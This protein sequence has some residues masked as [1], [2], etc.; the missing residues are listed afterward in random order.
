M[1]LDRIAKLVRL[2]AADADVVS[3][4]Q[5]QPAK[6][7]VP[8]NLDPDHLRVLQ[9]AKATAAPQKT[10]AFGQAQPRQAAIET[11]GSAAIQP[12]P[13]AA[14]APMP[15][16]MAN[17]AAP[18]TDDV[19]LPPEGA[20]QPPNPVII[21]LAPLPSPAPTRQPA[22][23]PPAS[24]GPTRQPQPAPAKLNPAPSQ[25]GPATSPT[26]PAPAPLRAP[27]PLGPLPWQ[28]QPARQPFGL[29]PIYPLP[30]L[31]T[32]TQLQPVSNTPDGSP[33]PTIGSPI[34]TIASQIPTIAYPIPTIAGALGSQEQSA[35]QTT[36]TQMAPAFW[37]P[38]NAAPCDCRL[39]VTALAAMVATTSQTAITAITGIAQQC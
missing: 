20:G 9:S 31:P 15:I 14:A 2:A 11:A 1:A 35:L 24:P 4:L 19:L 25:P 39:P 34:P 33:I 26:I 12:K 3:A 36:P 37:P 8:L 18:N 30:G 13:V 16:I 7:A 28:Q 32:L 6:L 22:A 38:Q 10:P 21:S 23:A 5:K 27:L 29:G 17:V